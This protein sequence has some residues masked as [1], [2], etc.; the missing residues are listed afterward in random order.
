[1]RV[2]PRRKKEADLHD[3]FKAK[4]VVERR[5]RLGVSC[6]VRDGWIVPGELDVFYDMI[7]NNKAN[8]YT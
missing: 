7:I 2:A 1:M 6:C 4:I 3:E 8:L 5:Y